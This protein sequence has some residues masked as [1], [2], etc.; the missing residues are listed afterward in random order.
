MFLLSSRQRAWDKKADC[1]LIR[2]Y[3]YLRGADQARRRGDRGRSELESARSIVRMRCDCRV[4]NDRGFDGDRVWSC[5]YNT[6]LLLLKCVRLGAS[7]ATLQVVT[8]KVNFT[9][10]GRSET[11]QL[12]GITIREGGLQL[13]TQDRKETSKEKLFSLE[14]VNPGQ[15]N[16]DSRLHNVVRAGQTYACRIIPA[17]QP[18]RRVH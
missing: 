16:E 8:F 3:W 5:L 2:S 7:A 14:S 1:A 11:G 4:D 17:A 18:L 12:Q 15:S 9:N 6:P 13:F 10:S